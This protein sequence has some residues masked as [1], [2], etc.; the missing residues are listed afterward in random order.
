MRYRQELEQVL[1]VLVV[2]T[3]FGGGIVAFARPDVAVEYGIGE[4]E[5][6]LVAFAA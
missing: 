3:R 4:A 2:D 5:I 6:V 1:A